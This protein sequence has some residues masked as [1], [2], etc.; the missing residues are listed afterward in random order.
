VSR[1]PLAATCER[2]CQ[3]IF[4]KY[5]YYSP[6]FAVGLGI[7]DALCDAVENAK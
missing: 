6:W 3:V 5:A 2:P 1:K 7:A 4:N